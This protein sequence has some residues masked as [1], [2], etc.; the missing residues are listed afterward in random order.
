[1]P[2][3]RNI[4]M[5]QLQTPTVMGSAATMFPT[6]EDATLQKC[7][8]QICDYMRHTVSCLFGAGSMDVS[9]TTEL[10]VRPAIVSSVGSMNVGCIWLT[11]R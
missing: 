7:A 11:H 9:E 2:T 5:L 4:A 10:L 1:M 6:R 8:K 3:E